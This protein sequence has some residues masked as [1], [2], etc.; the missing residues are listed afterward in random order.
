MVVRIWPILLA[1]SHTSGC[2]TDFTMCFE[3]HC[4]MKSDTRMVWADAVDYCFERDAVLP[5]IHKSEENAYLSDTVCMTSS[6]SNWPA[7]GCWIGLTDE[8]EDDVWL[9][10]DGT[11]YDYENWHD[12]E[13]SGNHDGDPEHYAHL[14]G[15]GTW[16]DLDSSHEL[17]AICTKAAPTASP[18]NPT[19]SPSDS[20]TFLPTAAQL[21]LF[22]VG[23]LDQLD[24]ILVSLLTMIFL[25]SVVICV[26]YCWVLPRARRD[27]GNKRVSENLGPITLED[28]RNKLEGETSSLY[29]EM[30]E[31]FTTT[32]ALAQAKGHQ[33]RATMEVRLQDVESPV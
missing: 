14:W 12:N 1:V 6:R 8:E 30:H 2:V 18:T 33:H 24:V 10:Q 27:C 13:P 31:G 23:M 28:E 26:L 5:S 19:L 17:F 3:E 15:T 4:Y 21:K 11:A 16:N 29:D 20:P 9:W 32:M 22:P 7:E 25:L